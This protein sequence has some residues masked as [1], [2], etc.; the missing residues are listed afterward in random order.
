MS[1]LFVVPNTGSSETLTQ[2]P[3]FGKS[4]ACEHECAFGK[5][6]ATSDL[7]LELVTPLG[8]TLR[9]PFADVEKLR[10]FLGAANYSLREWRKTITGQRIPKVW[11]REDGKVWCEWMGVNGQIVKIYGKV[12]RHGG[13]AKPCSICRE[14][15]QV[16][17]EAKRIPW[18][19]PN[20]PRLCVSCFDRF[21]V[22]PRR[23]GKIEAVK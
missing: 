18:N 3:I 22:A 23:M 13:N 8:E 10:S 15:A 14:Q 1:S 21:Q 9:L 16:R 7:E 2:S 17:W 6:R 5:L 20:L 4:R 19:T 12:P 11:T